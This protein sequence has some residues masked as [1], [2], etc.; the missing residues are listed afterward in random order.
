MEWRKVSKIRFS[1]QIICI[2][3]H[4]ITVSSISNLLLIFMSAGN[5]VSKISPD[6]KHDCGVRCSE[7]SI[8]SSTHFGKTF[9]RVSRRGEASFTFSFSSSH[10]DAFSTESL[11]RSAL[12]T[13][14]TSESSVMIMGFLYRLLTLKGSRLNGLLSAKWVMLIILLTIVEGTSQSFLQTYSQALQQSANTIHP[15]ARYALLASSYLFE[16]YEAAK[17]IIMISIGYR[18]HRFIRCAIFTK[19]ATRMHRQG[20]KTIGFQVAFAV[21]NYTQGI[22]RDATGK[23]IS[24]SKKPEESL[25]SRYCSKV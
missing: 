14:V 2:A 15:L 16:C 25:F 5:S 1:F 19:Q 24:L 3:S 17:F 4:F 21:P 18:T 23:P 10:Q 11:L 8:D 6:S 9:F 22:L 13:T 7:M 20:L 12:V